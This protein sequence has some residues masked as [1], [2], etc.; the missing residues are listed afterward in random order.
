MKQRSVTQIANRHVAKC[1]DK[2]E[3]VMKLPDVCADAIRKEF[4]WCAQD[5]AEAQS[6]QG[7]Q[8]D[9]ARGN[10]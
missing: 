8:D 10:R 3:A 9:D 6:Q 1:L 7:V 2:I 4:H 5:V